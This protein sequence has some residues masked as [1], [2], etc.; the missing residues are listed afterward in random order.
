MIAM[1][2]EIASFAL[3]FASVLCGCAGFIVGLGAPYSVGMKIV[4]GLFYGTIA[5]VITPMSIVLIAW[6]V[7]VLHRIFLSILT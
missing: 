7:V 5:A 2:Y 4:Y 3:A 1:N 6:L